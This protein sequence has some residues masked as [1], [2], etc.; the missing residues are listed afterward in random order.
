MKKHFSKTQ[1]MGMLLIIFG[2]GLF[3]D[4]I[5]G[6]FEPGGLIFCIYYAYVW[7]ALS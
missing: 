4:M 6:H 5:L 3:L 7:K 1:L 2:F